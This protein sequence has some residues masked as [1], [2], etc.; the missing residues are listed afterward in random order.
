M[1]LSLMGFAG[2]LLYSF[3]ALEVP[4]PLWALPT[5]V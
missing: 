4:Q 2:W 1:P 5:T 3:L